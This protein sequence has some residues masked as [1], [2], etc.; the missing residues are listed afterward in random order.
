MQ[1]DGAVRD[2][3]SR[4]ALR[5]L[6]D[7]GQGT[8][9]G[10]TVQGAEKLWGATSQALKAYCASWDLPHGRYSIRNVCETF[11]LS[12]ISA[13]SPFPPTPASPGCW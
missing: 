9:A 13:S 12:P 5:L 8:A 11:I 7:A 3:H 1:N 2:M 4:L 6:E 10:S